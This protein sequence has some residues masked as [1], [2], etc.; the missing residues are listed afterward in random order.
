MEKERRLSRRWRSVAVLAAGVAIGI[1]IVA[2]PAASHIGS[3]THLW[4]HHIKPKADARYSRVLTIQNFGVNGFSSN[5]FVSIASGTYKAA[6]KCGLVMDGTLDWDD[7]SNSNILFVQWFVDGVAVGGDFAFQ[8]GA[9]GNNLA[10]SATAFKTIGAGGHNVELRALV[11][12][13]TADIEDVGAYAFCHYRTGTGGLVS[14]TV[15]TPR[16]T[17]S[18]QDPT[19]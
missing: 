19:R 18:R 4:N 2:T 15:T 10:A 14:R 16:T 8:G 9:S 3:L 17:H 12:S 1:A 13:G 7:N 5:S 11:T 6:G